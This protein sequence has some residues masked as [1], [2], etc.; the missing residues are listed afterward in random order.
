MCDVCWSAKLCGPLCLSV[1]N[2]MYMDGENSCVIYGWFIGQ[3][4]GTVPTNPNTRSLLTRSL[5]EATQKT[6]SLL[7]SKPSVILCGKLAMSFDFKYRSYSP[8]TIISLGTPNC[9]LQHPLSIHP[10]KNIHFHLQDPGNSP[11]HCQT[12]QQI[13]HDYT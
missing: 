7:R 2:K 6:C 4:Q 5:R 13:L 9:L 1:V 12:D 8:I 3:A 11:P 10:Q